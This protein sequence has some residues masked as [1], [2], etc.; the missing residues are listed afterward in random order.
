MPAWLV[1]PVTDRYVQ[2]VVE[3][4]RGRLEGQDK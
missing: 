1:M 2:Q 4:V 3:A